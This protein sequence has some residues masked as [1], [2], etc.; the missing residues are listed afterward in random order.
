MA[1]DDVRAGHIFRALADF[2][3]TG[4]EIVFTHH[5]HLCEVARK[6][7]SDD[8]LAVVELKRA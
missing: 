6:S 7:V 2:S 1:S 4:Q 5:N 8:V 3:K